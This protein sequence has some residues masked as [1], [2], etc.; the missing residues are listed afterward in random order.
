VVDQQPLDHDRAEG[1]I[2]MGQKK[3]KK[4]KKKK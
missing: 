4:G 1:R 3:S 2:T